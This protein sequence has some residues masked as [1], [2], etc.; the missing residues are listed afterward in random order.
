MHVGHTYIS[1][2]AEPTYLWFV[3]LEM[4]G[5]K[6]GECKIVYTMFRAFDTSEVNRCS[7]IERTNARVNV[8]RFNADLNFI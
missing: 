6:Q 1:I 5:R 8:E 4:F 3:N 7:S 2:V